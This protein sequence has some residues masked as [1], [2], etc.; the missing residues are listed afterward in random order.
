MSR[1]VALGVVVAA[2]LALG[3]GA[4]PALGQTVQVQ[5]FTVKVA[6]N[7]A[8]TSALT[9]ASVQT[10]DRSRL[11]IWQFRGDAGECVE[12]QMS[13]PSGAFQPYVQVAQ[14][15]PSGTIVARSAEAGADGTA[16]VAVLLRAGD[17][18]YVQATSAGPGDQRGGYALQLTR[19]A[20]SC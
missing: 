4:V 9:A 2:L 13:V 16:V 17:N 19:Q 7:G 5:G 18:Y 3:G 14:G 8:N 12:I 6:E 10:R 20:S 1:R 15:R 11:E